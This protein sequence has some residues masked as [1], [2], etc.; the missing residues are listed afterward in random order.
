MRD[1]TFEWDDKKAARNWHSHGISF[2]MAREA[3][4]DSFAVVRVDDHH[5]SNEERL[6]LLGMVSN[7]LLFVSYTLR[8]E[9][10]HII[11]AR[12]AEPHERR[13]YHNQSD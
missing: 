11:S 3:F 2:E 12:R 4:K 1:E 6:A 13:R 5:D 7:R 8:G 9:R 10:T